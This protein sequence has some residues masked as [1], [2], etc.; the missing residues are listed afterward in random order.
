MQHA[1][2][3]SGSG[4]WAGIDRSSGMRRSTHLLHFTLPNVSLGCGLPQRLHAPHAIQLATQPLGST[5]E[6]AG[7]RVTGG[8]GEHMW[9][10]ASPKHLR[11]VVRKTCS[12]CNCCCNS[13][14]SPVGAIALVFCS[15]AGGGGIGGGRWQ[16]RK[17]QGLAHHHSHLHPAHLLCCL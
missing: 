16:V 6:G 15:R 9:R 14:A 10:S 12:C 7:E 11:T 4:G 8:G 3:M 5:R 2:Q 13:A 17:T 1:D